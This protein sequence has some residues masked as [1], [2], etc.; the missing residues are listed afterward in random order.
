MVATYVAQHLNAHVET[1]MV[2]YDIDDALNVVDLGQPQGASLKC[3]PIALFRRFR[4]AL[5]RSVGTGTV[6]KFQ[7]IA[8]TNA[9]G[10][11]SPTIVVEHAIGSAPDAVGDTIWLECNAEQIR[12]VLA[13]ATH[14]G[15]RVHLATATDEAV[16]LFERAE[17]L[18]QRADLTADYIAS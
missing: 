2:D 18:Y 12:E 15:V 14:V 6:T 10:T 4:A 7:I 9:A 1:R 3:L 17:P 8:A 11:G 5:F 13:T 16:V